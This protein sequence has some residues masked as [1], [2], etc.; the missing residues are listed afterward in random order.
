M[1]ERGRPR[2]PG[3]DEAILQA[4]RALMFEHGFAGFSMADVARH[5][6]VGRQSVYRR[7]PTKSTLAVASV[8]W[9]IDAD[10]AFPDRGSFEADLRGALEMLRDLYAQSSAP[11]FADVHAAM[12]G[13]PA[14]RGLFEQHYR[15]PRRDSL[16]RA[17]NRGIA[18]G[19]LLETT[20][21]EIVGDLVS[22]PFLHRLLSG[23]TEFSDELVDAIVFSVL[24][25]YGVPP[26]AH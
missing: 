8:T 25:L 24:G 4:A 6:G 22:G 18:R 12:S 15:Q 16:R 21:I 17:L 7:W 2:R 9:S 1:A 19:E 3:S 10:N 13:D 26:R 23:S 14:A 5:A 11:V 20:D